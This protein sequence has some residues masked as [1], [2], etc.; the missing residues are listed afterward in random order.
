MR[1]AV[2]E[3]SV[4]LETAAQVL[5]VAEEHRAEAVQLVLKPTYQ[6]APLSGKQAKEVI[7][8]KFIKPAEKAAAWESTM[9][10]R[11]KAWKAH[12]KSDEK[13]AEAPI[14]FV[15]LGYSDKLPSGD[16]VYALEEL[17]QG[18]AG[19]EAATWAALAARHEHPVFIIPLERAKWLAPE[20]YED[21]WGENEKPRSV[22][23][24]DS[25]ALREAEYL[26]PVEETEESFKT[27]WLPVEGKGEE[28]DGPDIGE[29]KRAFAQEIWEELQEHFRN[30]GEVLRVFWLKPVGL[31]L[32][33]NV[34]AWAWA[35][36][37][38]PNYSEYQASLLF[39]WC[40]DEELDYPAMVK[41]LVEANREPM[42]PVLA[43]LVACAL[44]VERWQLGG[45]GP[46]VVTRDAAMRM[47]G[48]ME[49]LQVPGRPGVH[50]S[51]PKVAELVERSLAQKEGEA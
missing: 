38:M 26:L 21:E 1:K 43:S 25:D 22:V 28:D 49:V 31:Y 40:D 41:G 47:F 32:E 50:V 16:V 4:S 48:V 29:L 37:M 30:S 45:D 24:V 2:G 34:K 18:H 35:L 7:E 33:A 3:K 23:V 19:P 12:C 51:L 44:D 13:A 17:P 14:R 10:K 8:E 36:S 39:G 9:A 27:R 11:L 5:R 6:Q 42:Y 15:P 46:F 20:G